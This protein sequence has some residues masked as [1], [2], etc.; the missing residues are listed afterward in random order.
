MVY[1]TL[2]PPAPYSGMSCCL[3]FVLKQ[4]SQ[5]ARQGGGSR[6]VCIHEPS[7]AC[8][9]IVEAEVMD[10]WKVIILVCVCFFYFLYVLKILLI[11]KVSK[12]SPKHS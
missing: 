4:F 6:Q 10:T 12:L 3:A 1:E 8:G 2:A 5:C 9:L 7:F 11:R